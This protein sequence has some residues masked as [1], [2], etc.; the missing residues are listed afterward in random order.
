[1]YPGSISRYSWIF[2]N[3]LFSKPHQV[4]SQSRRANEELSVHLSVALVALNG[5]P[6]WKTLDIFL[7]V[8]E[9]PLPLGKARKGFCSCTLI[10]WFHSWHVGALTYSTSRRG[11]IKW[12]VGARVGGWMQCTWRR[13]CV[14]IR[15]SHMFVLN[16][17]SFLQADGH[18]TSESI[19]RR[20]QVS[21]AASLCSQERH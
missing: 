1:M 17:D 4:T 11:F 2:G 6:R 20:F 7:H 12:T 14:S 10:V 13:G 19:L 9:L 15:A 8:Q 21:A 16:S 18:S 3:L 5:P